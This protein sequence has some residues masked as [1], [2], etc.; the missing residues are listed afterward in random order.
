MSI[1]FGCRKCHSIQRL[2]RYLN[3][4]VPYLRVPI[5]NDDPE[6]RNAIY[7]FILH[8]RQQCQWLD[9]HPK[10]IIYSIAELSEIIT[11]QRCGIVHDL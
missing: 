9:I 8:L 5:H 11:V 10:A 3:Y 7:I 1:Q 4:S 6:Q 2:E